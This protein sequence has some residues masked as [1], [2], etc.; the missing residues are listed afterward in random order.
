MKSRVLI[1]A[2][3]AAAAVVGTHDVGAQQKARSLS[4]SA[5]AQ[6]AQQRPQIVA[7]FGGEENAARSAYV[8][9]VGARVASQTNISGGGNAFNITTLNSPVVNAFAGRLSYPP[10]VRLMNNEAELASVA[11]PA[12]VPSGGRRPS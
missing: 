11:R 8:R 7:E 3:L 1:A 12:T 10:A 2:A 4:Q 6:A 5:V 9:R